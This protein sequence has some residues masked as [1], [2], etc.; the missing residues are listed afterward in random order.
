MAFAD[1]FLVRNSLYVTSAIAVCIVV[2]M[3][4][5][6]EAMPVTQRIIGL[7]YVLIAAHEWEE[8][9]F[10]GGFVELVVAL[11]GM[12]LRDMRLPKFAL[13]CITVYM[14]LVPFCL[15]QVHWLAIAALVLGV[16][17]PLAHVV[18]GRANPETRIYSPGMVTSLLF[19]LPLDVYTIWYVATAEHFAW[20]LWLA[21][22]VLLLV[23]LFA[24][25]RLIVVRMMGMDYGAF[26]RNA[27]DSIL[28]KRKIGS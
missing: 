26:V 4:F 13:F 2:Y 1:R 7:Y 18:A 11:T 5:N 25:Q 3:A 28:G 24:T 21:A 14:L 27:R 22:A 19:M 9:K 12:P 20:Y 17:E 16:V 10:P 6:W 15:P 8:L 23:P